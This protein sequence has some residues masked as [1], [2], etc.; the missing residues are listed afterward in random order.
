MGES[1]R[2]MERFVGIDVGAETVKAVEV[3]R[4]AS[5]L[6]WT[7]RA[8]LDHHKTPAP[9]LRDLLAS[10]GWDDVSAA[11][12][13]GRLGRQLTVERVPGKQARMAGFRHLHGAERAVVV[14][15]GAHGFSVLVAGPDGAE[16][17][18]ENP[19]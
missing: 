2:T 16:S 19:R 5:G 15:V 6:R 18:R 10:W 4:D 17:Y 8:R 3:T 11:C 7:R 14:D 1:A 9:V 12:A 13:T